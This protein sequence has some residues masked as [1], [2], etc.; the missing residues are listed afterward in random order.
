MRWE[1][2]IVTYVNRYDHMIKEMRRTGGL[3]FLIMRALMPLKC[4]VKA[5][6][7]PNEIIYG[8]VIAVQ[9]AQLF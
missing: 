4:S 9:R 3:V 6:L 2:M 7:T 5:D 1:P 8:E